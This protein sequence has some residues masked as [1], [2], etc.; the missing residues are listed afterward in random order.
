MGRHGSA[1]MTDAWYR[2]A[3][4]IWPQTVALLLIGLVFASS[5]PPAP[6]MIPPG[7]VHPADNKGKMSALS[8]L[9]QQAKTSPASEAL[10][11][12]KAN[13][14]D[15]FAQF[16]MGNLFDP[17]LD[18]AKAS[19]ERTKQCE[20]WYR[21]S[22]EQNFALAQADLGNLLAYSRFGMPP[23]YAEA[24]QWLDKAASN[25][26]MAQ[27]ELGVLFLLGH[28]V[29][30]DTT[31]GIDLVR[32]AATR[33]DAGAQAQLGDALDHGRY[34]L[35]VDRHEAVLLYQKAALQNN[36]YGQRLLGIHLTTGDGV[37]ADASKARYWFTR[38]AASGD[39]YSKAQ[40]NGAP[41]SPAPQG[42]SPFSFAPIGR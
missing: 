31:K 17:T 28:G 9:F 41:S 4:F 8:V 36:V 29:P 15:A 18:R 27:R 40:L 20:E 2:R 39:S 35:S 5:P 42:V 3:W 12:N 24:Y 37:E 16:F 14:G 32:L 13:G 7:W 38:A 6:P 19:L 1:W 30:V 21:K 26:P 33:G 22:A 25:V 23:D 11:L 34:G 10:L